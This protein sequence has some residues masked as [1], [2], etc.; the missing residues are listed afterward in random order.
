MMFLSNKGYNVVH[1][2]IP[3]A[4]TPN[5][6]TKVGTDADFYAL[7]NA[8]RC[9]GVIRVSATIGVQYM[10]GVMIANGWQDGDGIEAFAI[11]MAGSASPYIVNAEITLEGADCYVTVGITNL[12]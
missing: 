8:I 1:A 5:V 4:I 10:D 3:D 12:T 2:I 7:Y 9:S 11:S 6:K